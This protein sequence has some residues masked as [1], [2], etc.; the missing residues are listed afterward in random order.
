ML[1]AIRLLLVML[2]LIVLTYLLS[3]PG[4]QVTSLLVIIV[5]LMQS[6]E[7]SRFVAKTNTELTRFLEALSHADYSQRFE[8]KTWGAGFAEL[9]EVFT[10][11]LDDFQ[12]ARAEQEVE[13]RHL[14]SMVEHVPV[15]LLSVHDDGRLTLWNNSARRLFG[16][17]HVDCVADLNQFGSELVT[18]LSSIDVGEKRLVSFDVDGMA[19]QLSVSATQI[20]M[21]GK[22]EMLVSLQDIQSELDGAQLQAW[23]DL[24]RVLTHEI[25]NSITPVASL[26]K[27]A[28]DLV[29]D[30]K[31][32]VSGNNEL[33]EDLHDIASAVETV[34]RRSD[35][36]TQFVESY[37]RLTRLPPPNK[38]S[39]KLVDLFKQVENLATQKWA[40]KGLSI[41]TQVNPQDLTVNADLDMLE[42][43]LINLLQN[44]EQALLD[45]T[46]PKIVM[47]AFLNLR[48]HVVIAVGDNG[49]GVAEELMK[50]IFVPFFTTK[51]EGSGVGLSLTRQIMIAH[52][53]SVKLSQSELGGAQFNLT[54]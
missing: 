2:N 30:A 33:L 25:M 19:H 12:S 50:K 8:P 11:I 28:V 29:E 15:P 44:A 47:Q 40:E 18:Y 49:K 26:A 27:T 42:Q 32:K 6:I 51:K 3:V 43:L 16:T 13:L 37:R 5:L 46:N 53:G 45:T 36:L 23:Q 52:N 24:V 9:A 35:G 22:Q 17:H 54:F 39:I 7:V 38:I 14:K 4:Y 10:A 21:A 48:G 1:I 34:S 20:I 41:T 31:N